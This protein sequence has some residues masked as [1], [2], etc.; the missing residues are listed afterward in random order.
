MTALL[1]SCTI[2]KR[3]YLPG[4]HVQWK[5]FPSKA[6]HSSE[7]I[8]RA[9]KPVAN[10]ADPDQL[11]HDNPA[12]EVYARPSDSLLEQ[13]PKQTNRNN[14]ANIPVASSRESKHITDYHRKTEVKPVKHELKQQQ[15]APKG[16]A[17][18]VSLLFLII[19]GVL[20]LIG[21]LL[22]AL[23]PSPIPGII[24]FVLGGIFLIVPIYLF[25]TNI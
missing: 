3:V 21:V 22:I 15:A 7:A 24:F 20:I 14:A 19:A 9:D 12:S 16:D 8:S 23:I 5:A 4:Y 13:E 1:F 2:Q 6:H 17:A 10:A 25:F 18:E 11:V